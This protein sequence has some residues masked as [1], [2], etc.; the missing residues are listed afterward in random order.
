[1]CN[2]VVVGGGRQ[3]PTPVYDPLHRHRLLPSKVLHLEVKTP[4]T[5]PPDGIMRRITLDIGSPCLKYRYV[6]NSKSEMYAL[7]FGWISVSW[8]LE[9]VYTLPNHTLPNQKIWLN[10]SGNT[11]VWK[12]QFLKYVRKYLFSFEYIEIWENSDRKSVV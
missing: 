9:N 11:V 10:F 3:D 5:G 8:N 7:K 4:A 1:M 12:I 6:E 2:I